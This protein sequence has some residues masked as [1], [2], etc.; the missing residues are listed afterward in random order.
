MAAI[1]S[2]IVALSHAFI[3]NDDPKVIEARSVHKP[4]LKQRKANFKVFEKSFIENSEE[5]KK[6]FPEFYNKTF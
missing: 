1:I 2:V 6:Q 5:I 3:E 4:V